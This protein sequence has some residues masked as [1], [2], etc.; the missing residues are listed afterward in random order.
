[1]CFKECVWYGGLSFNSGDLSLKTWD[2]RRSSCHSK[3]NLAKE[4][5]ILIVCKAR[6]IKYMV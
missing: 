3:C 6:V 1:M 5:R 4:N 2:E